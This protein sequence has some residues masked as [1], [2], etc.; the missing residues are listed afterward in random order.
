MISWERL[1]GRATAALRRKIVRMCKTCK[2]RKG[3]GADSNQTIPGHKSSSGILPRAL[4]V[5]EHDAARILSR[6]GLLPDY[7]LNQ[8]KPTPVP[9]RQKFRTV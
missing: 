8:R 1:D 4:L 9:G 3:S 6:G 7:R 5:C 2:T